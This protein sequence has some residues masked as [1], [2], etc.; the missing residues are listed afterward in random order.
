MYN[1]ISELLSLAEARGV[2][3]WEIVLENEIKL[4]E[5]SAETVFEKLDQ[6]YEVMLN[7]AS[8]ALERGLPAVGGLITGFAS[9][10]NRFAEAGGGITGP[11]IN[12]VM[13]R[14][15]SCGEVNASMGKI[16]AFP[17]AGACGILP[18]VLITAGEKYSM[19]RRTIL[20]AML[21]ASGLGAVITRNATVS[22]AEGGCQAE[23]GAA[24]AMAAA[25]AVQMAGGSCR[26]AINAFCFALM[27][28]MGLVCD[29]IAG[30]VQM[31]CA[32]RNASQAVNALISADMALAGI[33]S[34][35]PADEVLEAMFHTGRSLPAALKETAMGGLAATPA[36]KKIQA[37][38]F[39]L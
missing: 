27:N 24:A 36:G 4:N 37:D 1:T 2:G 33:T 7:S 35:I 6:R 16:C 29:P 9:A 11:F 26:T 3:M 25:A 31:P 20:E 32:L 39:G 15:L 13:A 8:R 34:V 38:I 5:E 19:D 30:L 17:T 28:C 21:T 22:G 23:C 18:A 12:L 14:A 10:Q